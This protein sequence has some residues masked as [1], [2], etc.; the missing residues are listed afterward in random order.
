M[1]ILFLPLRIQLAFYA[2]ALSFSTAA[3][4][5]FSI[6]SGIAL[7]FGWYVGGGIMSVFVFALFFFFMSL[8]VEMRPRE[9]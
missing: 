5:A 3:I 6:L 2:F 4:K 8:L 9:P 7:P 1:V